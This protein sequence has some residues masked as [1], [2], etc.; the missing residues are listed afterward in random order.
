M[1]IDGDGGGGEDDVNSGDGND[2]REVRPWPNEVD[3]GDVYGDSD[4]E[5]LI[6]EQETEIILPICLSHCPFIH[7]ISHLQRVVQ[8]DK[9]QQ[10]IH[11]YLQP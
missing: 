9:A 11:I 5:M 7:S 2:R 1:V 8:V 3:G 4:S 10:T 6:T